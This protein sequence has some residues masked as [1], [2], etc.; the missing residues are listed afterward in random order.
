MKG[1]IRPWRA[2]WPDFSLRRGCRLYRQ[3]AK[4]LAHLLI[5]TG[6][7]WGLSSGPG[8]L[9]AVL[10][11]GMAFFYVYQIVDSIRSAHAVRLGQPA[12]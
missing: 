3:Y 10:G 2:F 12:P 1:R 5:F 9:G 8:S 4:G 6:I 11:L 7:I